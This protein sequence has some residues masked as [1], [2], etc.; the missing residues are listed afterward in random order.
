M[1]VKDIGGIFKSV[2]VD[3][4]EELE[5]LCLNN[6]AVSKVNSIRSAKTN[7]ETLHSKVLKDNIIAA[8]KRFR[9]QVSPSPASTTNKEMQTLKSE[10]VKHMDD[11]Y[12]V[13][14]FIEGF[15][16]GIMQSYETVNIE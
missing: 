13:L 1:K 15:V 9:F 10:L 6:T 11:D 16:G 12:A 4:M 2:K 8:K 3:T 14:D 5:G 7:W